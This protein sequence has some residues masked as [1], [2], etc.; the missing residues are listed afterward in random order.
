MALAS[1][2]AV[3]L[4]G[5]GIG[6]VITGFKNKRREKIMK[7]TPTS[8]IATLSSGLVEIQGTVVADKLSNSP[9]SNTPCVYCRYTIE[10]H[11]LL[12]LK[13][14]WKSKKEFEQ[15]NVFLLKDD[16]GRIFIPPNNAEVDIPKTY[17]SIIKH[18]S[19]IPSHV[20]DFLNKHK[21]KFKGGITGKHKSL[22]LREYRIDP[23]DTLYV[24]GSMDRNQRGMRYIAKNKNHNIYYISTKSE[25]SN[26]SHHDSFSPKSLIVGGI[27]LTIFSGGILLLALYSQL[28]FF[29]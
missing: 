27:I 2:L 22:R 14:E 20:M 18:D 16:S 17:E 21:I 25:K 1:I 29:F 9:F 5:V 12:S 26:L 15:N 13:N 19:D 24:L 23:N 3:S 6:A 11:E 7:N 28:R 10:E 4:L 8:K